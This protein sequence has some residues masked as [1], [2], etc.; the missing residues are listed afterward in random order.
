M[1]EIRAQ[2]LKNLFDA[3]LHGKKAITAINA[4]LFLESICEQSPVVTSISC[5]VSSPHG[6][7]ALLSALSCDTSLD[8]LNGPLTS[9]LEYIK[10]PDL[11]TI[12]DGEAVRQ[13]IAKLMEAPLTW[14]SFVKAAH[15]R[16]LKERALGVFSW[17]LVQLLYLP[18]KEAVAYL[19]VARDPSI[20]RV[21]LESSSYDVKSQGELIKQIADK[22]AGSSGSEELV[23]KI[24]QRDPGGRHDNDFPEIHR[25]SIYPT[26]DELK[27]TARYLPRPCDAEDRAQ[28]SDALASHID[29][30][31]RLLREDMLCELREDL[32]AVTQP[33][34]KGRKPLEIRN[35][36]LVGV[37]C[38][39]RLPWSV[40]LRCENDL[41][42]LRHLKPA[43]RA[44]YFKT[45]PKFL[46]TGTFVCLYV[47]R[48][49]V[50]LGTL[51][52]E[53][54]LLKKSILCVQLPARNLEEVLLKLN[55][56]T[57]YPCIRL[58][59][60][61]CA[62]FAY[63]PVLKQLQKMKKLALSPEIVSWQA[64]NDILPPKYSL[65]H[66]HERISSDECSTPDECLSS[67][68]YSSSDENYPSDEIY[69]L[70][71]LSSS[72]ECS[73]SSECSSVTKRL[74]SLKCN[75]NSSDPL[76]MVELESS[77]IVLDGAQKECFKAA[78]QQ[79]VALIQG[80]PGTGKSFIGA[81]IGRA[82]YRYS[83]ETILVVCYTHHA[84]DDFV[85]DLLD[86]GISRTD[87]VR[88]GSSHKATIHTKSL[89]LKEQPSRFTD[90]QNG[91]VDK[92]KSDLEE[93]GD[94]LRI[95][96]DRFVRRR[97]PYREV[98][99]FLETWSDELPYC[100]AFKIPKEKFGM[101]RV[102]EDGNMVRDDYLIHRWSQ[103]L[104]AGI[105]ESEI[106]LEH[107]AVWKMNPALRRK[108][109]GQWRYEMSRERAAQVIK[110][111]ERY[112]TTTEMVDS[113]FLLKDLS[114]L[115]KKR[116][117]ACTTT[118]AAKYSDL[119]N[120]ISPGV[121]LVEEAGEI[122]E[123]HVLAA[124]SPK[125]KHLILIGDH[126]QL[127]PRV[128][129]ELSVEKES[130]Y[131]LNR[132][133]F[134][135]LILKGFPLQTL[136][137]QHRMRPEISSLI[138]EMTYPELEDAGDTHGRPNLRGFSDNIIFV[139]H[140]EPETEL[141]VAREFGD[142]KATTSK[143]NRFEA[144]MTLKCVRYLGQQGYTSEDIVVLTPYLGQLR[145]LLDELSVDHDL[146]L[147]DLDSHDLARAGLMGDRED[148]NEANKPRLRISTI[149]NYQ[150][151]E[152]N[153]VIASLTR[154]NAA[155][156]IGFMFAPERLNVLVSRARN[157]LILIGNA[158][159]FMGARKG[160]SLW[161]RFIGLLKAGSH[162]YN[163]FPVYCERHP[164]RT[165]ILQKPVDFEIKC[166]AGG[167]EEPCGKMLESCGHKCPDKCHLPS[168]HLKVKCKAPIE[169]QCFQEHTYMV[170]CHA[171]SLGRCPLCEVETQ[172]RLEETLEK[173]R[174]KEHAEREE[175]QHLLKMAKLNSEIESIK[176]EAFRKE[177]E[178]TDGKP[179][180]A[181]SSKDRLEET[182][183]KTYGFGKRRNFQK[184]GFNAEVT[185]RQGNNVH[186]KATKKYEPTFERKNMS[187]RPPM[188]HRQ[189]KALQRYNEA[190]RK[191]RHQA[192]ADEKQDS[193]KDEQNKRQTQKRYNEQTSTITKT[194]AK[195]AT[196]KRR[197]NI[198]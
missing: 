17:L 80:P 29:C 167:C 178:E 184:N 196:I 137:T 9:F 7:E 113:L 10:A 76:P 30:Q 170:E 135:R 156:D 82:I 39:R 152:A 154:S 88:L 181:T 12:Q 60:I 162:V 90:M 195:Q 11:Q 127:R 89:A 121:L 6:L 13:I 163:G 158:E 191:D 49:F 138:R 103:G 1:A 149:D 62:I 98:L 177:D 94:I 46:K 26:P 81:L 133:L 5:L 83:G 128:N 105:Y 101:I 20:Q 95:A 192:N 48:E 119:L 175:Q 35:L 150:G 50:T 74:K 16:T 65:A 66:P 79:R 78:L 14:K 146:L 155:G 36:S 37:H 2:R 172:K 147:N 189:R 139:N 143:Q 112:N 164:D 92:G 122:L 61:S 140:S 179:T 110:W 165:N 27:A 24:I 159:H 108:K 33:K 168:N 54:E 193:S 69:S 28:E 68:E 71:E 118:A 176:K 72:N 182:N 91:M 84:L 41:P 134:E 75:N 100:H 96:F 31:F 161:T 51:V 97:Y 34:Q 111:G 107:E 157:A 125:T 104:N 136:F 70:D 53:E 120:R 197:P 43:E 160:G 142:L 148:T 85:K 187:F 55:K 45:R 63:E 42:Q 38:D 114:V 106:P 59:L 117:I 25:I 198:H 56:K 44:N 99:E 77:G 180:S 186:N 123:S 57:A 115:R 73:S 109:W 166:S 153:I 19:S 64:S 132:S 188:S 183:Q 40:K 174:R 145:L 8:F 129:F 4:S 23:L 190:V 93:D 130:G 32:A 3:V 126:K 144:Q 87:I 171:K 169:I 15:D 131:D 141:S 173:V 52:R 116:I 67:D 86:L 194:N 21:L 18:V 22:I 58:V 102:A 47:G 185:K 151:E 124:L